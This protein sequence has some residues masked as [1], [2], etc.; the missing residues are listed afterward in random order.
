ML[1]VSKTPP[2]RP[3][4]QRG[5]GFSHAQESTTAL[6]HLTFFLK[7]QLSKGT[8]TPRL[9][10]EFIQTGMSTCSELTAN[11]NTSFVWRL[12]SSCAQGGQRS[13]TC[14]VWR[15]QCTALPVVPEGGREIGV[16]VDLMGVGVAAFITTDESYLLLGNP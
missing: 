1:W 10:S 6:A 15:V 5:Q 11:K 13:S 7:T 4:T 16:C 8:T 2:P 14:L 9:T 12:S 3:H